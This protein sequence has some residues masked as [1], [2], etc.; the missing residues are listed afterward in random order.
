[1][2][3]T[4][5]QITA[6]INTSPIKLTPGIAELIRLLQHKQKAEVYLVSGG[7]RELIYPVAKLIGIPESNVFANRLLFH[8]NGDYMDFDRNE[9]TSD[10]GSKKVGKARACGY[11]K[12]T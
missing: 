8:P 11:L 6:Y 9:L 4:R 7:F 3:L 12:E 5:Q 2:Q 10:S 1:M